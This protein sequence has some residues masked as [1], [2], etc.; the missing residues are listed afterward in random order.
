MIQ[1]VTLPQKGKIIT[2][3]TAGKVPIFPTRQSVTIP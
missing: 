3:I 2:L 1:T